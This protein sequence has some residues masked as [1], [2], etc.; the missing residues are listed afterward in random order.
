MAR[1]KL[2]DAVLDQGCRSSI[3]S[4][5]KRALRNVNLRR[6]RSTTFFGIGERTIPCRK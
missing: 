3:P 5:V 1:S 6:T 4:T 2:N